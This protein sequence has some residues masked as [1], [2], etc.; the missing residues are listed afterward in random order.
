MEIAAIWLKLNE[1]KVLILCIYRAPAGDYD[2]FINKLD[3]ILNFL[4]RYNL[5]FILCGDINVN[6]L[7]NNNRKLKLDDMLNTY[8]LRDT[9]NFTTR[10]AN[11]S[12]TLIDNIFID[13]RRSYTI[14]P[15]INGLS[16]HDAQLILLKDITVPNNTL[17]PILVR[18]IN[19]NNITVTKLGAVGE[20]FWG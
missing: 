3:Y 11:D 10:I 20:Y 6:Y 12:T 4:Y 8:N 7:E 17:G 19:N 13:N 9:V 14:K 1:K 5:E 18:D 16:D 2:Y 15:C